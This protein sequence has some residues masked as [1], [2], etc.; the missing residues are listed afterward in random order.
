MASREQILNEIAEHKFWID[1]N[2]VYF[3]GVR[4]RLDRIKYLEETRVSVVSKDPLVDR[5]CVLL[6]GSCDCEWPRKDCKY[7]SIKKE[8][9][10]RK[11]DLTD[12]PP[13]TQELIKEQVPKDNIK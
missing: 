5:R 3:D 9:W 11:I 13:H 12:Y 10:P 2:P 7:V 8:L 4:E 6:D 1:K